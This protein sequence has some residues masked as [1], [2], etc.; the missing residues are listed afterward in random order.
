M[1]SLLAGCSPNAPV[2]SAARSTGDHEIAAGSEVGRELGEESREAL[3]VRELLKYETLPFGTLS[4][5][6]GGASKANAR[7]LAARFGLGIVDTFGE[8]GLGRPELVV[9]ASLTSC[10]AYVNAA[11][12]QASGDP[13]CFQDRGIDSPATFSLELN[14]VIDSIVRS[15][16]SPEEKGIT[17]LFLRTTEVMFALALVECAHS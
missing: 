13:K 4:R 3:C 7:K 9:P 10:V 17:L 1:A 15:Q 2:P 6:F 11:V 16:L 8:G 12:D 14:Q 5:G